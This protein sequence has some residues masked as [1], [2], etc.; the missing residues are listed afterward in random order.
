MVQVADTLS[1]GLQV[2]GFAPKHRLGLW[3]EVRN[4]HN[5][6]LSWQHPLQKN[7]T[8]AEVRALPC[9]KV[10]HLPARRVEVYRVLVLP[11]P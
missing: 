4:I 8:V 5:P 10:S 7:L 2:P 3:H 11:A 9:D 6:E 1:L